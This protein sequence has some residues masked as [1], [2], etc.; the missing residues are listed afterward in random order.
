M[1]EINSKPLAMENLVG[2][3]MAVLIG[4]DILKEF[5]KN[6]SIIYDEGTSLSDEQLFLER[7]KPLSYDQR[8]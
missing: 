8:M 2:G 4:M 6:S 1:D 7:I 5:N 3:F